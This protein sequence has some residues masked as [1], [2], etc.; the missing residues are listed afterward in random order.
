MTGKRTR[1]LSSGSATPWRRVAVRLGNERRRAA[2]SAATA[3]A[4]T[5]TTA[6]AAKGRPSDDDDIADLLLSF[7]RAP[8]KQV[9]DA[10]G[11]EREIEIAGTWSV[12]VTRARH[13]DRKNAFGEFFF[14]S[15]CSRSTV[16]R[17]FGAKRGTLYLKTE[18]AFFFVAKEE[19]ARGL[20]WPCPR[21][22][23]RDLASNRVHLMSS[24]Q[25]RCLIGD[26][27]V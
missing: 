25:R 10:S 17:F 3:A 9:R 21:R 12:G 8:T 2:S 20:S 1:G 7:S 19:L 16:G 27:R 5:A 14:S 24:K 4:T 18:G 11:A 23:P 22:R 13:R 26:V 6:T 15:L